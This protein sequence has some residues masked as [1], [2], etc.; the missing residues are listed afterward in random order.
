[1]SE[2][3]SK[4]V[5]VV[6]VTDPDTGNPVIVE[7]HKLETGPMVGIDGSY[8]DDDLFSPYDANVRIAEGENASHEII[9][10]TFVSVWDDEGPIQTKCKVN[11]STG[12]VYDIQPSDV[13]PTSL[14][15]A[16]Y[17][18]FPNGSGRSVTQDETGL[19]DVNEYFLSYKYTQVQELKQLAK[20]HRKEKDE[21]EAS[22]AEQE[23]AQA[24]RDEKRGLIL[25]HLDDCN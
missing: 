17:V 25:E 11:R 2:V 12:H 22:L 18:I 10:A 16:Q 13:V 21:L 6:E 24:I 9:D 8:Y 3:K 23:E 20:K 1:M 14:C 4:F 5:C 19:I 7:I 15:S